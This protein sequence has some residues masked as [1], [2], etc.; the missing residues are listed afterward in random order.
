VQH[1][2]LPMANL[3]E[4]DGRRRIL[5][6]GDSSISHDLLHRRERVVVSAP[7]RCGPA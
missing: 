7:W 2:D 4:R 6:W 3:Y 5:D 1:D